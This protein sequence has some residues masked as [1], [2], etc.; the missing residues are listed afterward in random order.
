MN[1]PYPFPRTSAPRH[2]PLPPGASGR[3]R[4]FTIA[5]LLPVPC[6]FVLYGIDGLILPAIILGGHSCL[7]F[8]AAAIAGIFLCFT[9]RERG[10]PGR[11]LLALA[12][13]GNLACAALAFYFMFRLH[14][15]REEPGPRSASILRTAGPWP[16]SPELIIPV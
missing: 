3:S 1:A 12:L 8:A 2:A 5:A 9:A 16:G 13:L 4:V 7:A 11:S 14:E 15:I 10:E 6:V